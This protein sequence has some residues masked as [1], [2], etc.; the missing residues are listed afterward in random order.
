MNFWICQSSFLTDCVHI[1]E[2]HSQPIPLKWFSDKIYYDFCLRLYLWAWLLDLRIFSGRFELV[3]NQ[4][5]ISLSIA[6][7]SWPFTVVIF[8]SSF[9]SALLHTAVRSTSFSLSNCV[10]IRAV[11][12]IK[13]P[14]LVYPIILTHIYTLSLKFTHS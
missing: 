13:P 9:S 4:F 3:S 8:V 2:I 11:Q 10:Q 12:L 1:Y 14:K 6:S 5:C 7:S